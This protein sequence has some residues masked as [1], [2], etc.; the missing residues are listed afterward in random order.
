M[1]MFSKWALVAFTATSLSAIAQVPAGYPADYKAIFD[2]ARKATDQ[3][4]RVSQTVANS[5]ATQIRVCNS[6]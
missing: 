5:T 3:T 2:G 1:I 4:A 6:G